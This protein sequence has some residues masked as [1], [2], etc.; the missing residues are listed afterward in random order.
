MIKHPTIEEIDRFNQKLDNEIEHY[1]KHTPS[2]STKCESYDYAYAGVDLI[3]MKAIF[4]DFKGW[5]IIKGK[6]EIPDEEIRVHCT[7]PATR[8]L[9]Y[10]KLVGYT[11]PEIH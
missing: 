2:W 4:C 10:F 6:F 5:K 8:K 11:T 7:K 1:N 3:P 9:Y